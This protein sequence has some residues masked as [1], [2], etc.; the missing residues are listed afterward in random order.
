MNDNKI[1]IE[2]MS[3]TTYLTWLVHKEIANPCYIPAIKA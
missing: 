1:I 2:L 3:I